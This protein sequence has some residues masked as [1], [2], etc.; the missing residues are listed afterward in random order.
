[1]AKLGFELVAPVG[2]F[3]ALAVL[4]GTVATSGVKRQEF[5]EPLRITG[6]EVEA[7]DTLLGMASSADIVAVVTLHNFRAS[8]IVQGDAPEDQ[9]AYAAVDAVF[10][11][12]VR[13]QAP[14][15]SVPLEFTLRFPTG[16]VP[17]IV[18]AQRGALPEEPVLVFLRHKGGPEEGLYRLVNMQGLWTEEEG[19]LRCPIARPPA[20]AAVAPHASPAEALQQLHDEKAALARAAEEGLV[21]PHRELPERVDLPASGGDAHAGDSVDASPE[22]TFAQEL[23][24]LESLE[25]L[26]DFLRLPQDEVAI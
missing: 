1:M 9:V 2:G 3:L 17:A 12:V 5:W 23:A 4:V 25:D 6:D 19:Q 14:G 16:D 13:G 18:S 24:D 7:F 10:E 26:V 21:R 15:A 20:A 22:A 11:E 8:R